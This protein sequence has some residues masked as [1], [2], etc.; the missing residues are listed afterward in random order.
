MDRIIDFLGKISEISLKNGILFCLYDVASARLTLL[1]INDSQRNKELSIFNFLQFI[2]PDDLQIANDS[3]DFMNKR[4]A[5]RYTCEARA[6]LINEKDYTWLFVNIYPFDIDKYG[7][8]NSYA[9]ICQDNNSWHKLQNNISL[10][11][12]KVT[13]ITDLNNIIF[14]EYDIENKIF[15]RLDDSGENAK[16]IISLD[17]WF[18]NFHPDDLHFGKHLL[19]ILDENKINNYHI[20]YRYNYPLGY[21]WFSIDVML[22][23]R[24]EQGEAISY[25]CLVRDIDKEKKEMQ[26]MQA[27]KEQAEAS[28]KLKTLFIEHLSHEI[29]T[30]LNA[31]LGFSSLM[32]N[33]LSDKEAQTFTNIIKMNTNHLLYIVDNTINISLLE[34][35][36]VQV[37]NSRFMVCSFLK[38]LYT[39][40]HLMVK[41]NINFTLLCNKQVEIFADKDLL[42]ELIETLVLN[43]NKF[44]LKGS[45]TIYYSIKDEGVLFEVQDTGIGIAQQDQ[46]RIFNRFE[47]V[48]KFSQ[49]LGLGLSLSK[50]IIEKMNGKIGVHSTLGKGSTFWFWIPCQAKEIE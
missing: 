11:R 36:F 48:D 37:N 29:R 39:S 6:K 25:L 12:K 13:Y 43:A 46:E 7:K 38:D 9:I 33:K 1:N 41:E 3:L 24:N 5:I 30:P 8:A 26:R 49:G 15:I 27:L 44:T 50:A 28:N 21:R 40:L 35:G 16:H 47:K 14:I 18:S 17:D 31:I 4:K 22:Y 2:H 23:N 19:S 42:K 20:E 32:T 34:A 45:I 10:Y